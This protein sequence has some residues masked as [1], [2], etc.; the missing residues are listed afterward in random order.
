MLSNLTQE[1]LDELVKKS[2][3]KSGVPV[4]IEDPDFHRLLAHL[5]TTS[6]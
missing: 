6:N 5:L 2:C 3:E 1:Q 4:T